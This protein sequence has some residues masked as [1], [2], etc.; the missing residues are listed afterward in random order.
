M[1]VFI[2]VA[3]TERFS[4]KSEKTLLFSY[5]IIS[6]IYLSTSFSIDLFPAS[7]ILLVKRRLVMW[8]SLGSLII[9]FVAL[10]CDTA[11]VT[12]SDAIFCE[13]VLFIIPKMHCSFIL[14]ES[15][16]VRQLLIDRW[17]R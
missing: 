11:Y 3:K 15:K 1:D 5:Q 16:R 4:R 9:H 2:M 10:F 17:V 8:F 12:L 13:A 6:I 7:T 14:H